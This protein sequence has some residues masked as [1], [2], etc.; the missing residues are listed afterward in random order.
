MQIYVLSKDSWKKYLFSHGGKKIKK[1]EIQ[2]T[3]RQILKGHF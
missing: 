1:L 2:K 3:K